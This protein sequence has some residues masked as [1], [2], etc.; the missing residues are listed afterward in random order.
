MYYVYKLY[1]LYSG[2]GMFCG[3]SQCLVPVFIW[4]SS[5][6]PPLGLLR[7]LHVLLLLGTPEQHTVLILWRQAEV[8]F[9]R[10]LCLKQEVLSVLIC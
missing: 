5:S 7:Q 6:W 2:R 4:E 10:T 3:L 1:G 9:A 8:I